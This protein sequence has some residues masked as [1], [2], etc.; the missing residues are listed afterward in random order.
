MLNA[1]TLILTAFIVL[2]P[3]GHAD[4]KS[5]VVTLGDSI[6]AGTFA[7]T[8]GP[9]EFPSSSLDTPWEDFLK[10]IIKKYFSNANYSWSTGLEI[11]SHL[12]RIKALNPHKDYGVLNLARPGDSTKHMLGQIDSLSGLLRGKNIEY[13]TVTVGANDICDNP[14]GSLNSADIE[15]NIVQ[16]FDELSKLMPKNGMVKVLLAGPPKI[17]DLGMDYIKKAYTI[18]DLT[19]SQIRSYLNQ[20]LNMVGWKDQA[21]Y[22]ANVELVE[23]LHSHMNKSIEKNTHR[24]G[25]LDIKFSS[26]LLK[27]SKSPSLDLLGVDCYHP[28]SKGQQSISDVLWNEQPW[29]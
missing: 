13:V 24:W 25:N 22:K 20:C 15:K 23:E 17:P 27:A 12:S 9:S 7:D 2:T 3:T 14:K 8:Q 21:E 11:E 28:S 19:C 18:A 4:S 5:Y 1:N 29:Y 26:G 6:S 10:H 16:A